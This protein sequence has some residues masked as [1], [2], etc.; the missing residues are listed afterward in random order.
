MHD[1]R[2]GAASARLA[3]CIDIAVVSEQ[4]GHST[5]ALTADTYSRLLGGVGRAAAERAMAL[6]PRARRDPRGQSGPREDVGP[7]SVD[8]RPGQKGA[9]P[10]TR[11][12]D[13]LIKRRSEDLP[14]PDEQC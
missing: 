11:T 10:G 12:P 8:E 7:S 14:E 5:I 9:P 4:L 13:P 2:H 1:L 6:V 3:A